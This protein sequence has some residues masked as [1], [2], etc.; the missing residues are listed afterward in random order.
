MKDRA[1]DAEIWRLGDGLA[2]RAIVGYGSTEG[3]APGV[4]DQVWGVIG[5]FNLQTVQEGNQIG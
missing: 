5:G 3:Q 1:P 2:G 4:K